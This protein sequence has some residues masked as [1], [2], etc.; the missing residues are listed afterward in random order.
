[1]VNEVRTRAGMAKLQTGDA[2]KPTYVAG[3]TE[4]R[5]RIRKERRLEFVAEGINVF[6]EMRWGTWKETVFFPG[7]G[8]KEIW[9]T[10]KYEYSWK[11]D[12][13]YNWAIPRTETEMNSNIIQ[14]EGWIN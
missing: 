3:Q 8:A 1:M 4:L 13:Q 14:N 5:E 6:D 9:G 12:F 7:N 11:S 10:L 2:S